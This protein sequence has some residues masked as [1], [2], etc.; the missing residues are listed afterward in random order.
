M[1][2][3]TDPPAVPDRKALRRQLLSARER[4]VL[5]EGFSEAEA[6][7]QARLVAVLADLVPECLGIYWPYPS[8]FN[9]ARPWLGAEGVSPLPLALPFARREPR[10]LHYRL[11]DGSPPT[12]QDECGIHTSQGKAVDPDVLLVPCVGYTDGGMRL[13]YGGGYFDR[14]LAAHPDVTAIGVAW[15]AGRIA[16]GQFQPEPHDQPLMLIVTEKG[17][18]G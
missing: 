9:A 14:Y 13:G 15:S 6:A 7:L 11:W 2:N 17:I 10:Q 1:P 4:F 12:L 8:E 18:V 5:S 16:P 3:Q